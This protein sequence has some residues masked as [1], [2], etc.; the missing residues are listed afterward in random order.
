MRIDNDWLA[1]AL[2]MLGCLV[3][4]AAGAGLAYWFTRDMRPQRPIVQP[5]PAAVESLEQRRRELRYYPRNGLLRDQQQPRIDP[6]A[7]LRKQA[8]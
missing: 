4:L 5:D 8:G 6:P 3:G 2:I 7:L 1:W